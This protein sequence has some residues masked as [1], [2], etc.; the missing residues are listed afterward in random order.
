MRQFWSIQLWNGANQDGFYSLPMFCLL[1][2]TRET[3]II[4]TVLPTLF[5]PRR[6]SSFFQPTT[7]GTMYTVSRKEDPTYK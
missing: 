2:P 4:Q 1:K 5:K 6:Q 3:I 7:G